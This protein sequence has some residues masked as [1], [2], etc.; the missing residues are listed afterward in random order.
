MKKNDVQYANDL[1]DVRDIKNGLLYTKSG[2]VIGYLRLFSANISLMTE[3]ELES[4]CNILC[5]EYRPEKEEFTFFSIP[6]A[7]DMEIYLNSLVTKAEGEIINPYRKKV[8]KIMIKEATEELI[9]SSSYEHHYFIRVWSKYN[10]N[11]KH[12]EEKVTERLKE[13]MSRYESIKHLTKRLNDVEILKVNNL[14]NNN[15]TASMES[16]E[17]DI[18]YYPISRIKREE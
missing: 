5:S 16:Y 7:V 17:D 9:H 8:I 14:Y 12:G 10:L 11:D 2:Y 6:R 4:L 1:T 15:N 18:N 13:F 3:K